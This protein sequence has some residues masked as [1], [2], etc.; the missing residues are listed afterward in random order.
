MNPGNL[1]LLNFLYPCPF[2]VL[3]RLT[4]SVLATVSWSSA[5]HLHIGPRLWTKISLPPPLLSRYHPECSPSTSVSSLSPHN[6]TSC[7][8]PFPLRRV[9]LTPSLCSAPGPRGAQVRPSLLGAFNTPQFTSAL[10]SLPPNKKSWS[11]QIRP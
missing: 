1:W 4:K 10:K 8:L 2:R 11:P 5:G 3:S 9:P 7:C 6:T